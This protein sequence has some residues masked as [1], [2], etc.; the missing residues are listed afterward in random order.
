MFI[1]MLDPGQRRLLLRAAAYMSELDGARPEVEHELLA[2]LNVEAGLPEIPDVPAS[3]AEVLDDLA[4]PFH[5]APTQRNVLL[6]ELAGVAMI[7]GQ[8]HPEEV[9][10]LAK[11]SN[12]LGA[13][14]R[15]VEEALEFGAA[16]RDL[17]TRGHDLIT[18]GAD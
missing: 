6:L 11:V 17:M 2:A 7:D 14:E 8:A 13:D 16:A 10:F 3:E 9:S 4:G 18:S 5:D 15:L 12:R 1:T